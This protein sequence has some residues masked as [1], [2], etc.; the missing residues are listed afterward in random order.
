[1]MCERGAPMCEVTTVAVLT[2]EDVDRRLMALPNWT[3]HGGTIVRRISFAGFPEAVAFVSRLVPLAEAADHH[4]DISI[5]Y[6]HVTLS[7]STHSEGGVTEKDLLA[8][9]EVDQLLGA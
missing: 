2:A 3:R 9:A 7:Y 6:R 1:M 5:N 4:P 8:A